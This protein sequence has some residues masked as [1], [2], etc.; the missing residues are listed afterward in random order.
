M[1]ITVVMIDFDL[2][3]CTQD[4]P[5]NL[6][7]KKPECIFKAILRISRKFFFLRLIR[8]QLHKVHFNLHLSFTQ[9]QLIFFIA[10]PFPFFV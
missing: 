7:R 9:G 3:S 6:D 8:V 1:C 4:F 5:G 10:L 2:F